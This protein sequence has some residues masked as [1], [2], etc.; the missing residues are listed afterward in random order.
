MATLFFI[1]SILA[2][3]YF[4]RGLAGCLFRLIGGLY[5]S[6]EVLFGLLLWSVFILIGLGWLIG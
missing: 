6:I 1:L 3:I 4:L 2:G 5:A